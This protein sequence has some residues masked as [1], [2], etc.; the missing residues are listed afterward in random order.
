MLADVRVHFG[1]GVVVQ[2]RVDGNLLNPGRHEETTG[3]LVD[4]L[5]LEHAVHEADPVVDPGQAT[6]AAF[7]VATDHATEEA[8][9]IGKF[10]QLCVW[11]FKLHIV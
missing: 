9:R 6:A 2:V 3:V 7:D 5:H 4:D 8:A 1:D 10:S 11:D